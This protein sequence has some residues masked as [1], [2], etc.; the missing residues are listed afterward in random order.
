[1]SETPPT[2]R[3]PLSPNRPRS[4]PPAARLEEPAH[5]PLEA[6]SSLWAETVERDWDPDRE[7]E[8]EGTGAGSRAGTPPRARIPPG[9]A[10]RATL[11]TRKASGT[12]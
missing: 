1:M 4:K 5:S 10:R 8:R 12:V 3:R 7:R 9:R 11:E 2:S 6:E